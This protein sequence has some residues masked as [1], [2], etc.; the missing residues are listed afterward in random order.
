M[1]ISG[2]RPIF[3]LLKRSLRG[4]ENVVKVEADILNRARGLSL[5]LGIIREAAKNFT[6]LQ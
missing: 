5:A 2:R 6:C 3:H 1:L 4:A